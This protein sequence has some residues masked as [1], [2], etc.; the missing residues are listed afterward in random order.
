M[1][2]VYCT[3]ISNHFW[4]RE[5]VYCCWLSNVVFT[6]RWKG[7]GSK[8]HKEVATNGNMTLK[9]F[10]WCMQK[11]LKPI[12]YI[13]CHLEKIHPKA[14]EILEGENSWLKGSNLI[15]WKSLTARSPMQAHSMLVRGFEI[16]LDD[17]HL[18]A[19]RI[20]RLL[21]HHGF[22]LGMVRRSWQYRSHADRGKS[23]RRLYIYSVL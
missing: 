20:R 9:L 13:W 21:L 17:L 7:M 19:E 5:T 16:L 15:Q 23:I 6:M 3:L 18:W 14:H 22:H 1:K 4:H 8:W 11:D 12:S 2:H 10:F